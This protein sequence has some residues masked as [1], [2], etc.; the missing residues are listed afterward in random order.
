VALVVVL[1][2]QVAFGSRGATG[3]TGRLT[4]SP[5]PKVV[6][7][8]GVSRKIWPESDHFAQSLTICICWLDYALHV[9]HTVGMSRHKRVIEDRHCVYCGGL[10]D[11]RTVRKGRHFDTIRDGAWCY[12]ERWVHDDCAAENHTIAAFVLDGRGLRRIA[13]D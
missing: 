12:V 1:F 5:V 7:F 3:R 4:S 6:A 8:G 13:R 9:L 11:N 10:V 2:A